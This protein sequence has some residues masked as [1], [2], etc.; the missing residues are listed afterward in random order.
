MGCKE[1]GIDGS[2]LHT[3]EGGCVRMTVNE[4]VLGWVLAQFS[5]APGKLIRYTRHIDIKY[6]EKMGLMWAE[7]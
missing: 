1:V 2:E 5:I 6:T 3:S 7:Y 4:S